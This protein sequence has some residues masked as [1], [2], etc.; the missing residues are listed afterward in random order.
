MR[1]D[2]LPTAGRPGWRDKFSWI[3]LFDEGILIS[4]DDGQMDDAL[5]ERQ[6]SEYMAFF[7]AIHNI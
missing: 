7:D 6:N 1:R 4:Y 5:Y 3:D 2:L